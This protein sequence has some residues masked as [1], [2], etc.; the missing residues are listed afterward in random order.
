MKKRKKKVWKIVVPVAI[1]LVIV[2]IVKSLGSGSGAVPVYTATVTT[3]DIQS[4]LNTSGTVKAED[5]ITY[6]APANAKIA[7]IEIEQGDVVKAGDVLVCFDEEAVAYA[8]KQNELESQI[9]TAG[10]TASVQDYQTQ[11]DKLAQANADIANYEAQIDNYEQYIEDLTKGITDVA[12]KKKADLYAK[13]YSVQKEINAYQL[14]IQT[15]NEDTDVEALMAKS[16]EKQNELVKLQN[17]LNL[18]GDTETEY[19][20]EDLLKQ[21]Q[22]DLADLETKLQEAK[23][24]KASAEAA[25]VNSNKLTEYELSQ[26]KTKLVTEDADRK[27]E[28][29]LNGVVAEFDGVVTSLSTVEGAP[30]QEGTQLLVLESF[31]EICVEFQASKYDLEE[32]QVGQKAIIDVSGHAYEGTVSKI[33]KMAQQNAS[34]VPMVTARVHIDNPD[35]N[36]YLGIEA[37]ITI[38][39]AQEQAVLIL[40]VEAVNTDNDGNFCYLIENGV[41]VKRYIT[42]GVSSLEYMQVL[43]GLTEGDEIVTASYMGLDME[44]GMAVTVMADMVAPTAVTEE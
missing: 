35:E 7:G 17:E 16:T 36:I 23:S 31:E 24:N 14:A 41:L 21:A 30:V 8:K 39:T 32:L 20:W 25:M 6:F 28:E 33:N 19:G 37:K 15:P 22:K 40:P 2:M 13:I 27:Y 42:T 9:S 18:L 11:K 1:V 43:E 44:E 3:G 34:G 29:A 38:V 12:A 4:E 26:K 5:S 10:Y